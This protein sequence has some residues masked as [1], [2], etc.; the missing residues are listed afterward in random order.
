MHAL[1]RSTTQLTP[2]IVR[3]VLADGDLDRFVMPADTDTYVNVAIPPEGA[4]YGGVF[5]AKQVREEHPADV[6]PARRRYTVRT[7]DDATKELT[8]DF[9]VHGTDGVAG[10]WA[11]AR[12]AGRR[13]RL[14]RPRQRLPA[15]TPTPT[16]TSWS[17]TSRR[18][19]RSPRR[20]RPCPTGRWSSCASS[21]TGPTTRSS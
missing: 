5:D 8:L 11:A 3:I 16:G 18:C 7:W 15:R 2:S 10:P 12:E 9:V 4:P 6:Q 17:A 21:A 14:R 1:V 19:R 20:S 13:A